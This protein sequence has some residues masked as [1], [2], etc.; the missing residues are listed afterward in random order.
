MEFFKKGVPIGKHDTT[1]QVT[2]KTDNTAG[3][4]ATGLGFNGYSWGE[5]T[6]KPVICY[7]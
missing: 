4:N 1:M 3:S 7:I 6:M 5:I 2:Y